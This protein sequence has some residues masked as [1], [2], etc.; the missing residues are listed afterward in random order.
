MAAVMHTTSTRTIKEI[1]A[2]AEEISSLALRK[3]PMPKH[4]ATLFLSPLL[5]PKSKKENHEIIDRSVTQM[6]YFSKPKYRIAN[7]TC[8]NVNAIPAAF[9]MKLK[10]TSFDSRLDRV[11]G[12]GMLNVV[13]L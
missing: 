3:S 10:T 8:T 2:Y 13:R 6:P 11:S 1:N 12:V 9:S 7:G 4:S 5:N